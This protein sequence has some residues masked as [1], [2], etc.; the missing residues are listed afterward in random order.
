MTRTKEPTTH[1]GA[2]Q[3]RD[4][5]FLLGFLMGGVA[6][7]GLA[8]FFAPRVVAELRRRVTDSA[9]DLGR[10]A[11]ER[12]QQT[13][14]RVGEAVGELNR[15]GQKVRDEVLEAVASGAQKVERFAADHATSKP[16]A[17]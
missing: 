1:D 13:S 9:R 8:L 6:G 2:S 12:Y 11:A 17:R 10:A 7:A 5:R 14:T 15:K 3:A 4:H 16:P